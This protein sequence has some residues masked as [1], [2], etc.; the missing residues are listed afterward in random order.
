MRIGLNRTRKSNVSTGGLRVCVSHRGNPLSPVVTGEFRLLEDGFFRLLEDGG[1]RL[2]E[3]GTPPDPPDPPEPPIEIVQFS[4]AP[5][6]TQL[7][8]DGF[9]IQGSAKVSA[10]IY[11]LN[12]PDGS[13]A[14]TSA[15]VKAAPTA[16]QLASSYFRINIDSL[17]SDSAYDCYVVLERADG[18]D[19]NSLP[20]KVDV[21]TPIDMSAYFGS[22]LRTWFNTDTRTGKTLTGVGSNVCSAIVC[23][24]ADALTFNQAGQ[25]PRWNG[26]SFYFRNSNAF[27]YTGNTMFNY[28]H[29]GSAWSIA[30][31]L[32][33]L[34]TF[35]N[36]EF[37]VFNDNNFTPAQTG[38]G[39]RY[40]NQADSKSL[41][42]D[43]TA[44]G[45]HVCQIFQA[46]VTV[47]TRHRFIVTYTGGTTA[48]TA[49]MTLYR[50][51][52]S[53]ATALNTAS[54]NTGNASYDPCVG[55]D[56]GGGSTGFGANVLLG[57]L[58]FFN[59]ILSAP[60]RTIV[61][62][63]LNYGTRTLG[64]GP[65]AN[66]YWGGGQSNMGGSITS[67]MPAHLLNPT[68]AYMYNRTD[69]TYQESDDFAVAQY[70]V[71]ANT[72]N[73]FMPGP[74]LQ[75][76]Y[77]MNQLL[78]GTAFILKHAKSG[79]S[80]FVSIPA[81]TDWNVADVA[82]ANPSV[83]GTT[84][85]ITAALKYLLYAYDR[86]VTFR[87][88]LWRQ[89]E[90]DWAEPNEYYEG[91]LNL[92]IARIKTMVVAR[93]LS[94]AKARFISASVDNVVPLFGPSMTD[95]A[96]QTASVAANVATN[97]GMAGGTQF[98]TIGIP[99]RPDIL[100]W[101]NV[102]YMQVGDLFYNYLKDYVNE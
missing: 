44:A 15:A 81:G 19:L 94:I 69:G 89:G 39:I 90:A 18:T 42:I 11:I 96:T 66:V 38:L 32:T 88:I 62:T 78:P 101:T 60:E 57:N 77:K 30:F 43:L 22:N 31:D 13:A 28:L 80:M 87:G 26:K 84:V 25:I 48:G 79:S 67:L 55:R 100:H 27:R 61:D 51:G 72:Y 16:Q 93:G 97:H 83:Q 12:L 46:A 21:R 35:V 40:D 74:D 20:T 1:F 34:E 3:D 98:S 73:Q 24:G 5:N 86:T 52:V 45:T 92:L 33:I 56:A 64:V 6:V 4:V 59:K 71:N 91:D 41:Y 17:S 102:G 76:G 36:D 37:V 7:N 68:G 47:G 14:P 85:L 99:L 10:N 9:A 50:D 95:I 49:T 63:R 65:S 23:A 54:H 82:A 75:F 53:I 70:G 2:F 29:D 8:N 58:M